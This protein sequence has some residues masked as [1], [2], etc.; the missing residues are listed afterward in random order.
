MGRSLQTRV[1]AVTLALLTIAA[2]VL[3]IV[4]FRQEQGFQQPTDG[5]W[6][7]ESTGALK[8]QRVPAESAGERAGIRTGDLLL[9]VNQ[10]P[11]RKIADLV[12]EQFRTKVYGSAS[13]VISR[14]GIRISVPV[15]LD[16]ADTS[17]NA[18]L[19]LIA[20]VY[21]GIGLYVLFRRWTAP[22]A[23][24]FY[25]FC[26]ASFAAYAFH[27][28]GRLNTLD[29]T[30]YWSG[31]VAGA[32]QPA[33]FLH[34]A[35]SFGRRS[36][37]RRA[38]WLALTYV[39]AA[40]IVGLQIY[41][42]LFWQATEVLSHRLDQIAVAYLD[43]FYILATVLFSIEYLRAGKEAGQVLRRQQL[44]WLARG[45]VL[46][47]VPFS[48][49]YVLPYLLDRGVPSLLRDLAILAL[50]ILPLT[51]AWAIVRYRLMDVDLIFKRGVTYALATAMVVGFYFL[52]VAVAAELVRNRLPSFGP[53]GLLAAII[54][55]SALFDPV[56]RAIQNRMDRLFDRRRYDYRQTLIDFGRTLGTQTDLDHLLRSITGRLAQTLLVSRIA[57][58]LETGEGAGQFRLGAAHGSDG[59]ALLPDGAVPALGFLDFDQPGAGSHIFFENPQQALRLTE[60]ERRTASVLE[61]HYYL[62]C[63]VQERTIAVIGLGRTTDGDFLSSE[64]VELLESLAGYVGHRDP[65]RDALRQPAEQ[66]RGVRAAERVQR[67]YRRVDQR[68]HSRGRSG[69]ADRELECADGGA[70]RHASFRG[71]GAAAGRCLRRRVCAGVPAG[72][73]RSR[74]APSI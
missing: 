61:L 47:V 66:D 16:A 32:V 24:H 68:R 9:S 64:D 23:S 22:H 55:T 21:L 4:N 43:S 14:R 65:E 59:L 31:I 15:I 13:Y 29:W 45:S 11:T 52:L 36:T 62:P 39:P 56:K 69:G 27:Y 42:I 35:L 44:K 67:E 17:I 48:L 73:E 37:R 1:V 46:S 50:V 58:F 19:R 54:L 7:V 63:R 34:F 28:T 49:F 57:V 70:F 26:V 18:G 10:Q 6:W 8:A 2:V 5:I 40:L 41:A 74:G 20:L 25:I 30:V 51:F 53:Y 33:L 72:E 3:A 71:A 60:A 12:R 38:W